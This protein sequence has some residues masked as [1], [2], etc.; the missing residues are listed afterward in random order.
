[1]LLREMAADRVG[2]NTPHRCLVW[3]GDNT[4]GCAAPHTKDTF[5]R[6]CC[7]ATR[8][9]PSASA[10][11]YRSSPSRRPQTAA[12]PHFCQYPEPTAACF[13]AQFGYSG[14]L[15]FPL[16]DRARHSPAP[17][18]F[19]AIAVMAMLAIVNPIVT[20][21]VILAGVAIRAPL[22]ADDAACKS[23]YERDRHAALDARDERLISQDRV[24]ARLRDPTTR[25]PSSVSPG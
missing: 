22:R 2:K 1:L 4:Y 20:T 25:V 3:S 6:R 17:I 13:E 12:A 19:P 24:A 18:I 15:F 23:R 14:G 5:F 10:A 7:G 8:T 16:D 9:R 11:H 21:L